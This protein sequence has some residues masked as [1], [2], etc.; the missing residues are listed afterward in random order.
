MQK[1]ILE[2]IFSR[3]WIMQFSK[4]L[5][6]MWENMD[7]SSMD[8]YLVATEARRNYIVSEPI[9]LSYNKHLF[10]KL[11][12]KK[13]QKLM[14]KPI[15][16]GLSILGLSKIVMYEFW[17]DYVKPKFWEKSKFCYNMDTDS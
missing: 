11:W 17:D 10:R 2:K 1:M 4:K 15:Y 5:W 6:P 16:L 3:W 8:I 7:I 14:K 13:T 12:N 9:N